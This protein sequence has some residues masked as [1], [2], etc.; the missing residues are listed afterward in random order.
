MP[1]RSLLSKLCV[2]RPDV[3]VLLG[4]LPACHMISMNSCFGGSSPRQRFCS[5]LEITDP[6]CACSLAPACSYVLHA[7]A[8][9]RACSLLQACSVTSSAPQRLMSRETM[10]CYLASLMHA[11]SFLVSKCM[12][13][14]SYAPSSAV[15][16]SIGSGSKH[17]ILAELKCLQALSRYVHRRTLVQ[18]RVFCRERADGLYTPLAYLL[19]RIVEEVI[20]TFASTAAFSTLAFF[21]VFMSGSYVPFFMA[22]FITSSVGVSWAYLV[23]AISPSM[24][25]ANAVTPLTPLEYQVP[26]SPCQ[27][28][29]QLVKRN[30]PQE[31]TDV[32]W[33]DASH[34]C[35]WSDVSL[36]SF[37][38]LYGSRQ[39]KSKIKASPRIQEECD[40]SFCVQIFPSYL[41]LS[42]FFVGQLIRLPDIPGYWKW[43]VR[44]NPLQ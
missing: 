31:V 6:S 44:I 21:P 14:C 19:A 41:L 30:H 27:V 37:S 13:A 23:A 9:H 17:G 35:S 29:R 32:S 26:T 2:S 43:I 3:S 7:R 39:N 22:T 42:M 18:R 34:A 38:W 24:A 8:G 28:T 11:W 15:E 12:R 40:E 25:I 33:H 5:L 4:Q 10:L 36:V 20:I 16:D 1:P